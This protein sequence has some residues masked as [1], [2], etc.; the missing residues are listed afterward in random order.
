MAII[1]KR[2]KR[3]PKF[4]QYIPSGFEPP[5][6]VV[7]RTSGETYW[8]A[9]IRDAIY[10]DCPEFRYY[11]PKKGNS[12]TVQELANRVAGELNEARGLI[13][14]QEYIDGIPTFYAIFASNGRQVVCV[15]STDVTRMEPIDMVAFN[16]AVE[17]F[18]AK[19]L[20]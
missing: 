9:K 1:P 11:P 7:V 15:Q 16:A 3:S 17:R 6:M 19:G 12:F 2:K 4:V 13:Q 14:L 20:Q 18:K 5:F 8:H 10:G